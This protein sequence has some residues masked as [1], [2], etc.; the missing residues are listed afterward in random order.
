LESVLSLQAVLQ[1]EYQLGQPFTVGY[2]Q[3]LC[4]EGI[5]VAQS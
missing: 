4:D 5:V 3:R 1:P 2:I